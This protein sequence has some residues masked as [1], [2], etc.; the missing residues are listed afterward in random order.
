M[1]HRLLTDADEPVVEQAVCIL[2]NLC[3]ETPENITAALAWAGP[4][5][6][7]VLEEKLD[8]SRCVDP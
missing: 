2:R 4:E 6:L 5:L 1:M 8:P 3:M 7:V